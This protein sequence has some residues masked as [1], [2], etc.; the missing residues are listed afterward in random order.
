MSALSERQELTSRS[1]HLLACRTQRHLHLLATQDLLAL[2]TVLRSPV[3]ESVRANTDFFDDVGIL[4][5]RRA[6]ISA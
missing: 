2:P 3:A 1:R 5:L 4:L 6:S